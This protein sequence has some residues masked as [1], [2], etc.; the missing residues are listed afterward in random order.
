MARV[1]VFE[2]RLINCQNISAISR[3]S[4]KKPLWE[5][6]VKFQSVSQELLYW[7]W[8]ASLFNA[9]LPH[10]ASLNPWAD[11]PPPKPSL[12]P[13]ASGSV[14]F[15]LIGGADGDD[16][17]ADVC[18]L[19]HAHFVQ[20]LSEDR[21]V[22]VDVADENPHVRRVCGR[23]R[24]VARLNGAPHTPASARDSSSALDAC[25]P[26]IRLLILQFIVT[27]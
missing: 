22:V 23:S 8:L 5:T 6:A 27:A 17:Q 3:K 10:A 16:R 24:N 19:V 11:H 12:P 9:L 4:G 18:V 14:T 13:P 2:T 26:S 1:S 20:P 7:F 21:L 15:I 25:S